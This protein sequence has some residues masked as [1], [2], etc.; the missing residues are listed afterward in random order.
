MD[1]VVKAATPH[2]TDIGRLRMHEILPKRVR[3]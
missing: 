2:E 1:A 3:S